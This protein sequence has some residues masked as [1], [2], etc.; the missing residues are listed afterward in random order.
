MAIGSKMALLTFMVT[1]VLG[2][3]SLSTVDVLDGS[4]RFGLV[5]SLMD[6]EK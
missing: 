4:L 1:I 5:E 2:P 3:Y 6:D